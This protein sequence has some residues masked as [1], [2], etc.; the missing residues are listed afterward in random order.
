MPKRSGSPVLE[1][2]ELPDV[3][4]F[5]RGGAFS[6]EDAPVFDPAP[7]NGAQRRGDQC[8][9][10]SR[11][12]PRPQ[13]PVGR[14]PDGTGVRACTD[15]APGI[16]A[17]LHRV[18]VRRVLRQALDRVEHYAP[19]VLPA[20]IAAAP[21]RQGPRPMVAA[22]AVLVARHIAA[23]E[24]LA[25]QLAWQMNGCDHELP[26]PITQWEHA[27]AWL[28]TWAV[29]G[30]PAAEIRE[31]LAHLLDESPAVDLESAGGGLK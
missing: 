15:C 25:A 2:P 4:W 20:L 31:V 30:P 21:S 10:C 29:T 13:V 11:K 26:V 19:Q 7:L 27:E 24:D 9:T 22:A 5:E 18:M 1:A 28:T 16:V 6:L 14:I 3:K 12:W 17:E 8:V 23:T